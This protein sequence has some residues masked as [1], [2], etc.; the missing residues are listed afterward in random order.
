M[1]PILNKLKRRL[2]EISYK[3]NLIHVGSGLSCLE[4]LYNI[5]KNKKESDIC[6]LSAGHA[7]IA[8]YTVL[9]EMYPHINAQELYKKHGVHPNRDSD[10]KIDFSSGSLG[11]GIT[12]AVGFALSDKKRHVYCVISDGECYE[13]SVW[14]SLRFINENKMSNITIYVIINGNSATDYIDTDYLKNRLYSFYKNIKLIEME[15]YNLPYLMGIDAHYHSITEQEYSEL[16]L[17]L[18]D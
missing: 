10:N 11:I 17:L 13:G 1:H 7:A 12:A 8:L 14:E 18:K 16:M 15:S 6:I 4:T 9:E 2:I 3:N 5:Y